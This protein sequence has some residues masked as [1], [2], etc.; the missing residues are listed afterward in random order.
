MSPIA[1]P[2]ARKPA[3]RASV[4]LAPGGISPQ[5]QRRRELLKA[6]TRRV[7]ER[8]G[9]RAMKVTDVAAEAG[10]AVGLFYHYFP[11]LKTV[12]SE[13]LSDFLDEIAAVPLPEPKDR[14]DAIYT[15]TLLWA[16]TF[17]DNPG[18]M[19]CLVQLADEVPEFEALWTRAS[20][21]WTR[22][23]AKYVAKGVR[24]GPQDE[25]SSLSAAYALGAMVDGLLQEIYVHRN[26]DLRELARSPQAVATLLSSMWF[27]ALYLELPPA[28]PDAA[29]QTAAPASAKPARPAKAGTAAGS[30][31][32][33]ARKPSAD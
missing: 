4:D 1:K 10:V 17:R 22:R 23:A 14:Y 13:I 6:A 2:R 28:A 31:R 8:L 15:P 16:T 21:T 29:H 30:T 32:P 33:R 5:G 26:A 11:D 20:S 24:L 19:R 27:R 3:A 7:L 18:L 12:T 9:Y 25:A